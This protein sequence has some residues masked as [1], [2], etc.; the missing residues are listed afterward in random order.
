[1]V[2]KGEPCTLLLLLGVVPDFIEILSLGLLLMTKRHSDSYHEIVH[3]SG[4]S[5]V[6][7]GIGET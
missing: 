4:H 1:M 6:A 5:F 3:S 2:V 7:V